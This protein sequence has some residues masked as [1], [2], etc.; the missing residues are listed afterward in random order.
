MVVSVVSTLVKEKFQ[1]RLRM[2]IEL[3]KEYQIE[4]DEIGIFGSYARGNYKTTSDI[5][6]AIITDNRPDMKTSGSFREEAEL[7]GV[8]VVYMTRESFEYSNRAFNQRV[9]KEYVKVL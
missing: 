8:D 6:V 7:L 4:Y 5:D 1:K 3:L 9:R 2:F